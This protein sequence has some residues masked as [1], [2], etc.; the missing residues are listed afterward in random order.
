MARFGWP[1]IRP[2]WGRLVAAILLGVLFGL[3][4][5][6]FVYVTKTLFSRLDS[7]GATA[8][9]IKTSAPAKP[10]LPG[11]GTGLKPRLQKIQA[12]VEK[13]LDH[14]LPLA[15]RKLDWQQAVGAI[16]LLP[17]LVGVSR[18]VG[19]LC[20]YCSNWVS[21]RVVADL[22]V[23]LLLKLQTL[24][25]DFFNRS[26]TGDLLTRISTDTAHFQRF[27]VL[28][29]ADIIKEPLTIASVLTA[30]FI[31][32]WK[33]SLVAMVFLPLAFTPLIALGRK[34]RKLAKSTVGVAVAQ[35]GQLV[36]AFSAVRVVKA[37]SL[38]G[39]QGARYREFCRQQVHLAMKTVQA[40]EIINPLIETIAMLGLGLLIVYIFYTGTSIPNL[41]GF[42]TGVVLLFTPMKKVANL[43][44]M[45]QQAAVSVNRLL[46]VFAEKPTV[47]EPAT[48]KPLKDFRQELALENVSF[49]YAD[50]PV[51][52]NINLRL[53]RGLKL[54]VAGESGCGK[55]T[56]VNLLFR[57][58]DPT[59]GRIT[60]DGTDLREVAVE[61]LHR[62]M[63]LV[64]QEVFIFD[65]TVAENIGCGKAGATRAEIEAAARQAGA[66]E[67]IMTL[68]QGYDSNVGERGVTLSGGQRQRICIA[69]A[70]VRNAPILILDEATASLDSH[71]EAE[72]QTAIERLEQN[73]T[74]ICI[75]HRLSTLA[76][77]DRIVV[78]A[79]GRIVEE[80]TFQELLARRGPF[81]AMA[82]KQ[83]LEATSFL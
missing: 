23:N 44:I 1:Y 50:R 69:R 83:G 3:T 53:P 77:M 63:A 54:G 34:V 20:T 11:L 21:E 62:L 48:P 61:D 13:E 68:P 64:S 8:A 72:V 76:A 9:A 52:Q 80:G 19:Y 25:L 57:F 45:F 29:V 71:A 24:S 74:V 35:A 30:L 15:G 81:A 16:F 6:S 59:Q 51:L 43:H 40:K 79:E 75:A 4:N 78:L 56:L 18:F 42:V 33:L 5:A 70:F 2:Y 67:F 49:S 65:Q 73:R 46:E 66:H 17:L 26:K 7:T 58:Y 36:E 27:M 60:I 31:M 10:A 38:E 12:A 32:D 41:I 28:G 82:A 39:I 22:R 55:S 14:W 37:F 47:Q